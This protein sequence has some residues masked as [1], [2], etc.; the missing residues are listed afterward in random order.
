[1]QKNYFNEKLISSALMTKLFY[2]IFAS[3]HTENIMLKLK[4]SL[5]N[6]IEYI[7]I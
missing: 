1:M 3:K 7:N 4:L 2:V 6:M 5:K